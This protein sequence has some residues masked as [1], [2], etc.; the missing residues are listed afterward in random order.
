M[1]T[2]MWACWDGGGN[3]SPSLG[4]AKELKARGHDVRFYG[5]PDMVERT[6]DEGLSATALDDTWRDLDRYSFHPL[7]TV[8][9]YTSSPAVGAEMLERAADLE[10]DV[11]V[12]DAISPPPS[13]SRRRFRA[14]PRSCSTR[15]SIS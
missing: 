7:A 10:P 6:T 4:I 14:R 11:V 12:I 15:S 13:T 1:A 3:L 2:I 8:F 9:G 5:R